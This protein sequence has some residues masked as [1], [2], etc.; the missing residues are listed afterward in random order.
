MIDSKF[1]S[2]EVD[3]RVLLLQSSSILEVL[4]TCETIS[5]PYEHGCLTGV[6]LWRGRAV[7]LMDLGS[8]MRRE[9]N[10]DTRR[11][12]L[13]FEVTGEFV[14][15]AV[16]DASEVV[17]IDSSRLKPVRID[18]LPFAQFEVECE[19][20]RGVMTVVDMEAMVRSALV[21][22]SHASESYS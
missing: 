22:P 10:R 9:P 20:D 19:E 14:G 3:G 6:F 1:L 2:V 16:D 11:R 15:L 5:L 12:I 4:G 7:P 18:N 13:V 17:T 21:P 8:S